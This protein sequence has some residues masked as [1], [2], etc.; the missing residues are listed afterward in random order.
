MVNKT[1]ENFEQQLEKR[2]SELIQI[3]V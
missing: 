2:E 3:V 1:A